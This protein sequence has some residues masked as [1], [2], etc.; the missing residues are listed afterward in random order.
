MNMAIIGKPLKGKG[1]KMNLYDNVLV[2]LKK[3]GVKPGKKPTIK[4]EAPKKD[5]NIFVAEIIRYYQVDEFKK[6]PSKK[7]MDFLPNISA[8]QHNQSILETWEKHF[9]SMGIPYAIEKYKS[10]KSRGAYYRLIKERRI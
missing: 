9:Q 5:K 4:I 10:T 8:E 2:E 7:L 6:I 3:A 1:T